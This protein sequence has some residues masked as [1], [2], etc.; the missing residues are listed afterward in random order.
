VAVCTWQ[1]RNLKLNQ[2]MPLR[3]DTPHASA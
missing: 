1:R 3:W 2:F